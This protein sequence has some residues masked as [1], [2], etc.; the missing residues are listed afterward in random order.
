MRKRGGAS[1]AHQGDSDASLLTKQSV[2]ALYDY[3]ASSDVPFLPDPR[4]ELSMKRGDSFQLIHKREED[5]WCLVCTSTGADEGW[6]CCR[7]ASFLALPACQHFLLPLSSPELWNCDALAKGARQIR[8]GF[9]SKPS[10]LPKPVSRNLKPDIAHSCKRCPAILFRPTAR[11]PSWI[12][13]NGNGTHAHSRISPVTS[14]PRQAPP[15]GPCIE[16]LLPRARIC[17]CSLLERSDAPSELGS[18]AL[19]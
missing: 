1:S 7:D 18:Y 2:Q 16:S 11:G 12:P 8:Y 10:P 6:V 5:G 15:A 19:C 4:M 14:T 17:G 3:T 9:N 13:T